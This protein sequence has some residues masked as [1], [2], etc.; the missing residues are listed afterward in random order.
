MNIFC[1]LL[2]RVQI[3]WTD[4]GKYGIIKLCGRCDIVGKDTFLK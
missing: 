1:I 3:Q 4:V 2:G